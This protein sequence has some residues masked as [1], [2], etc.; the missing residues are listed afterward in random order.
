MMKEARLDW[1]YRTIGVA[2][3]LVVVP[4]YTVAGSCAENMSSI[5]H[6]Q[7]LW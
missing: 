6:D 5:I 1:Y 3:L 4:Y 7:P 2:K